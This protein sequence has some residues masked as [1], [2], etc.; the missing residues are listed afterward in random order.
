MSLTVV[1]RVKAAGAPP[2]ESLLLEQGMAGCRERSW[3]KEEMGSK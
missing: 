1:N 3:K 2:W